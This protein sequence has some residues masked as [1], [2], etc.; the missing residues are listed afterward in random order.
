MPWQMTEPLQRAYEG[1]QGLD[2]F[3]RLCYTG[4]RL[5]MNPARQVSARDAC[6][7]FLQSYTDLAVYWN[8]RG[9]CLFGYTP[10][11][12][13]TSHWDDELSGAIDRGEA[14]AWNPGAFSTPMMEDFVGVASRISRGVHPGAVPV[15]TIRKYLVEMR[16]LW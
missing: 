5:F 14:W 15:N 16:R 3:Q 10:K 6:A 1:L 9:W 13:F 4:D 8:S 7:K 12:H 2:D 11:Y